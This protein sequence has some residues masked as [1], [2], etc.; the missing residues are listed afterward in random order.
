MKLRS[1]GCLED[2]NC[3][4]RHGLLLL[5]RWRWWWRDVFRVLI[6]TQSA[7]VDPLA[8][9]CRRRLR[10]ASSGWGTLVD[11]PRRPPGVPPKHLAADLRSR[12]CSLLRRRHPL[13]RRVAGWRSAAPRPRRWSRWRLL[14]AARSTKGDWSYTGRQ[15]DALFRLEFVNNSNRWRSFLA[16]RRESDL[17]STANVQAHTT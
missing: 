9:V 13:R 1:C 2:E 4:R 5:L 10:L 3:W 7:L 14:S 11:R 6:A 8:G 16:W 15:G 17:L 12:P